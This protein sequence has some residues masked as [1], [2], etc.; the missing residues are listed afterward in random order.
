MVDDHP[1]P[2]YAPHGGPDEHH[3]VPPTIHDR[4]MTEP[5]DSPTDPG[6][7]AIDTAGPVTTP[8]GDTKAT[9]DSSMTPRQ[10]MWAIFIVSVAGLLLEVAYTRVVSYKLW[11]YYTYLVIGLALL[12][13]GS[14]ATA[15]VLSPRLRAMSTRSV[16]IGGSL[17]SAVTVVIGYLVVSFMPIET[18]ALWEYGTKD[19]VLNFGSLLIICFALFV[20]FTGIGVIVS[21]LLGRGGPR[22]NALYFADLIG[23]AIACAVVVFLITWTSP[24]AVIMLAS[25]MLAA[26]AAS[27]MPSTSGALRAV[28]G[29]AAIALLLIS[30][31]TN[32]LPDPRPERSKSKPGE[33]RVFS[34]WG[35]V[36]RVDVD[37]LADRDD[38]KVL[39]HDGTWG[40]ALNKFDG[41]PSG[42]TRFETD[43]RSWPF[44]VLGEP[45][46]EQ[47]IIGSA[48]GNE[49]V[50]SLTRG[51]ENIDAV[52]L[53][54]VTVGLVRDTFAD[55]T[56]NLTSFDQV[57]L[58][59]G[60]GR[61]FL[62]R[63][64]KSY[65]L[66]WFVAPDSYAANNAASAGAF[67][68]SESYLYTTEMIETTLEHLSD[69]GISVAQFGE[70]NFSERPNRTARY[71]LTAREAFKR[72]GVD[73]I[74]RHILVATSTDPLSGGLSTIIL[75]REP[76]TDEEVQRFVEAIPNAEPSTLIYAPGVQGDE[77][78]VSRLPL[79]DDDQLR[80]ELASYP[81][82]I[83]AITDNAPFFWHFSTFDDVVS[84]I[85]S[86]IDAADRE[87]AVGE[88]VLL[89][90]A[91]IATIFAAAFLVL[92]FIKIRKTWATLPGK[93][94]SAIY[95]A[96][97]GLGFMFFEVTLI[98][99]LSLF[100]GYPTY[101]LTVTLA[102]ILVFTGLGSLLSARIRTAPERVLVML[103]GALAVLTAFYR[104]AL[105]SITDA[106][107]SMPFTLRVIVAFILVSPLGLCLGMF[108]P[109]GLRT[110]SDLSDHADEYV[111][112]GWAINGAFSVVGS[113]L[114]TVLAMSWGF[115]TVQ[116][117]A[118]LVYIIAGAAF[119]A[120]RRTNADTIAASR[121]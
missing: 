71:V 112:W 99:Q 69:R 9:S 59:L 31:V 94:L 107:L 10:A 52:E 40:S 34:D 75:K 68:L 56:G 87:T 96:A 61:T 21:T 53:N 93:G 90:L 25:V 24:P 120:L 17:W 118:L 37:E 2:R 39:V 79:L 8:A 60:D 77:G 97:L 50:T 3:L 110:V 108:M 32:L 80:S 74:S 14:G 106:G 55:F 1:G 7:S 43:P 22:I 115:R 72:L 6:A 46:G 82:Q 78:I 35:P 81:Y 19:S 98:Q 54:P 83:H 67:V 5:L 88:R 89:L 65:D 114:T 66:V 16:V 38:L 13:L 95:F 45:A 102:S 47:L 63:S 30:T 119:W 111:A 18:L 86:S 64:D 105:P 85:T 41:D 49:I 100:L 104:F 76:F 121:A 12:G 20:T 36:F 109:T 11:Y 29:V 51:S 101:S 44:D 70:V 116:L 58:T 15:V 27:T 48:G 113:V 117:I 42:V 62:A 84:R 91:S 26:L 57:N 92:P 23:A 4:T 33:H 73:D 28:V 103:L